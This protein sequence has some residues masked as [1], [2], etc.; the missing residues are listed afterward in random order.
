MA[1]PADEAEDV[2]KAEEGK[3]APPTQED[4][5]ASAAERIRDT[6]KWLVASFAAVGGLL[7]AGLQLKDLGALEGADVTVAAI[8]AGLGIA[9]VL[10]VLLSSAAVLSAGR[11]PMAD[12]V[13]TEPA[14]ADITARLQRS[15][16]LYQPY[17]SISEFNQKLSD[18]WKAQTEALIAHQEAEEG[19]AEQRAAEAR[20]LKADAYLTKF[21]PINRRLLSSAEYENVR[22]RWDDARKWVFTGVVLAAVGAGMFGFSSPQT[23]AQEAAQTVPSAPSPGFL[24]LNEAGRED[25]ADILGD[26]CEARNLPV[27]ALSES[28]SGTY[29]LVTDPEE[30]DGCETARIEVSD[31]EGE[32][33][34][35]P[36]PALSKPD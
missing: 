20:Y 21:N 18:E 36:L 27:I 6:A 9:G 13:G 7:I 31:S 2:K 26:E 16:N 4:A 8:G 34:G 10:I 25:F 12:L 33:T 29:E 15:P 24:H 32:V 19:S 3:T 1:K 35:E 22:S 14:R 28:A 30:G 5:L 17:N 23:E 11:V